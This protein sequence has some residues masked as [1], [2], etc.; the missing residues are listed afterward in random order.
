MHIFTILDVELIEIVL[1]IVTKSE[2]YSNVIWF[3][4]L[5]DFNTTDAKFNSLL[6]V[7]LKL[8]LMG[9][10][11]SSPQAVCVFGCVFS[12]IHIQQRKARTE[13]STVLL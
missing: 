11:I 5:F 4:K 8:N 13:A 10:H 2:E 3:S 7:T 12:C 6:N 9:I 1:P